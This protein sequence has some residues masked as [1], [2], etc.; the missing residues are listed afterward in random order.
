MFFSHCECLLIHIA[1]GEIMPIH[2]H[3]A[4]TSFRS[5]CDAQNWCSWM[6]AKSIPSPHPPPPNPP[7]NNSKDNFVMALQFKI[8]FEFKVAIKQY[9]MRGS[10]IHSFFT[11]N[12]ALNL[13]NLCCLAARCWLLGYWFESA[14]KVEWHLCDTTLTC[15]GTFSSCDRWAHWQWQFEQLVINVFQCRL[16]VVNPESRVIQNTL[17]G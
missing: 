3:Q 6:S 16:P 12:K 8:P 15:I 2:F 11:S 5:K 13:V 14:N 7:K 9:H 4:L 10:A 1:P 17:S